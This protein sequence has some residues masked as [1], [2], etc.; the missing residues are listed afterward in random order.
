MVGR[1]AKLIAVEMGLPKELVERVQL[2]GVLHDI[3]KI[4][5]ADSIVNKPDAL[6]AE[7]WLEMEKHPE[8]GARM[9]ERAELY[10]VAEWVLAH[11]ER[12]DG[13]GYPL[14]LAGDEI[15]LEA[16]I[17]AV[18]DAYEA[19]THDRVYRSSIGHTAARAELRR[20]A[21]TQFDARA[22]EAF[23]AAHEPDEGSRSRRGGKSALAA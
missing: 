20:T 18:A 19:M 14:G 2:A 17:V 5:V 1:Y 4:G 15:P 8:F 10:D 6:T 22:V 3:G 9:L 16:R 23:L 7:E 11:H 21:G 13:Q 12:P